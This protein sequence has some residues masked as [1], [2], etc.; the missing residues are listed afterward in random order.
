MKEYTLVIRL[1][2]SKEV[3]TIKLSFVIPL[4]SRK[5]V[6]CGWACGVSGKVMGGSYKHVCLA[7]QLSFMFA[8]CGF[9]YLW[10]I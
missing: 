6:T 1:Q 3:M 7:K 10:Y 2:R 8:L 9:L 5:G 4:E